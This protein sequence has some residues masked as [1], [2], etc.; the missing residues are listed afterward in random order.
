MDWLKYH[1]N[2]Q[3]SELPVDWKEIFKRDAKIRV[4]I[5]FGNG[6]FLAHM[7][8]KFPE[9]NFIGF[10]LSIT[11]FVKAQKKF[12]REGI[13][14]VRLVMVDGRFGIRELFED[15]SVEHVYVNFPCP[16]SKKGQEKKRI[17]YGDFAKALA[18]VLEMGGTFEL[19]TDDKD[20]AEEVF[21]KFKESDFFDIEP[22]KID[23]KRDVQTR[24]EKKWISMGRHTFLIMA[25]KV[26]RADVE[27][28]AWGGKYVHQRIDHFDEE[29][30]H[31]LN[32]KVFK[33]KRKVFVVKEIYSS[34]DGNVHLIKV[35][36]SDDG[37]EQHYNILVERRRNFW[38]VKLDSTCQPY[39]TPSVKWSV[40]KIAQEISLT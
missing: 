29:R 1:I 10:E 28:I 16:W 34:K 4:E 27:R 2:P 9:V 20:Y 14:N 21:S 35:I 19:M 30:L 15:E 33:D 39:R 25:R 26:K 22:M 13:D 24:Y 7:A 5:G 17:T 38:I 3:N 36:S 37:F 32:G 18:A 6:E 8:K 23:F 11:S 40:R 12:Y 31:L